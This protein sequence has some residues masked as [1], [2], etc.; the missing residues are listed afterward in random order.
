MSKKNKRSIKYLDDKKQ[1]KMQ[2]EIK[3][4]YGDKK[5][6]DYN[7]TLNSMNKEQQQQMLN[8]CN[9]IFDK[10]AEHI[11]KEPYSEEVRDV[12]IQWHYW[13]RNFYEPSMELLRGLGEMYVYAPDFREVFEAIDPKLPDF[14]PKAINCYVDELEE[15]WLQEQCNTLEQ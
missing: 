12:L 14:L 10:L 2:E 5:V 3:Q 7:Q 11:H 6:N 8:E 4:K 1:D 9:E 15:K 13:I